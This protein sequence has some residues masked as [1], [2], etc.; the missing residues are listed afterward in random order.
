[1]RTALDAADFGAERFLRRP[2][3]EPALVWAVRSILAEDTAKASA[4]GKPEP[5]RRKRATTEADSPETLAARL[6]QATLLA[7]AELARRIALGASARAPRA[8]APCPGMPS[9]PPIFD[10]SDLA[11]EV[12]DDTPDIARVVAAQSLGATTDALIARLDEVTTT[13]LDEFLHDAVS[14]TVDAAVGAD[15]SMAVRYTAEPGD[16]VREMMAACTSGLLAPRR[17]M[18]ACRPSCRHR[19]ATSPPT[20]RRRAAG[21]A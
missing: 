14:R 16:P 6:E 3:A 10:A 2:V 21:V 18:W 11:E 8:C 5:T 4:S 13:M 1:M 15:L 7:V 17:R 19:R 12:V 9:E 20:C